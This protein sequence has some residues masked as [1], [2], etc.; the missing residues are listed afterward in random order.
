V[1]TSVRSS[2]DTHCADLNILLKFDQPT[3]LCGRPPNDRL[4]KW[5]EFQML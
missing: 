4:S 5:K 1:K 3:K 2:A